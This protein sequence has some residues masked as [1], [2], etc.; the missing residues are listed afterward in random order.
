M[1]L[2]ESN[3]RSCCRANS[4]SGGVN[5][6]QS[7]CRK[8]CSAQHGWHHRKAERLVRCYQ[9][10]GIWGLTPKARAK[11]EKQQVWNCDVSPTY[12]EIRKHQQNWKGS[13]MEVVHE[14]D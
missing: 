10:D 1:S 14:E 11:A 6:D 13:S 9:I 12:G 7:H 4:G 3:N 8:G 2:L 5:R